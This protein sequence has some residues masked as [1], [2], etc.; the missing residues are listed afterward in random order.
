MGL[1]TFLLQDAIDIYDAETMDSNG[2]YSGGTSV[3]YGSTL[4]CL[5]PLSTDQMV[6][7]GGGFDRVRVNLLAPGSLTIGSGVKVVINSSAQFAS[8]TAFRVEGPV[9][10]FPDPMNPAAIH[11]QQAILV[12][13]Q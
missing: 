12:Q 4:V 9:Q 3:L 11:H 1:P 7:L 6:T 5:T 10:K 13:E 8:A 2:V